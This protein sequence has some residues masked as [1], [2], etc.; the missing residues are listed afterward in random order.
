MGELNPHASINLEQASVMLLDD[1]PEGMAILVQIITAFGVKMLQRATTAEMAEKMS[2]TVPLDLV[3]AS[4]TLRLSSGY[5]FTS[6]LRRSDLKPN[7]Y[8]PVIL[9][10][11]HTVLSDVQKA[12]DCGANY[13]VAKPL[14]PTVLLNRIVW[15][16]REKRPFVSSDG[17]V[18]PE[19]RFHDVGPPPDQ[20]DR[21]RA[22]SPETVID[23]VTP[24]L[25]TNDSPSSSTMETAE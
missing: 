18:G 7:A 19:R 9:I 12:R 10:S 3:L 22:E 4:A 25:R 13:I 14:S 23:V 2:G 8:A 5:D 6:W 17:Y 16:A 24:N 15:V 11:G 1:N 21:R 20:P